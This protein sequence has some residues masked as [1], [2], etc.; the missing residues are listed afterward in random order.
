MQ[1]IK[2]QCPKCGK[3]SRSHREDHDP[4][5]AVLLI[6]RC[7]QCAVGCKDGGGTYCYETEEKVS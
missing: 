5:A 6:I 2:I 1:F 7:P 3:E 4:P